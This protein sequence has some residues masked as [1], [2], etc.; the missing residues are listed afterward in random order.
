MYN[1]CSRSL[2]NVCH[3]RQ[4]SRGL[5][6]MQHITGIIIINNMLRLWGCGANLQQTKVIIFSV[7]WLYWLFVSSCCWFRGT[8]HIL[9]QYVQYLKLSLA[10][11]LAFCESDCLNIKTPQSHNTSLPLLVMSCWSGCTVQTCCHAARMLP[12]K[13]WRCVTR[14][15]S[16][17]E[18]SVSHERSSPSADND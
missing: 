16:C 8:R 5:I 18:S 2:T 9:S 12:V 3:T 6:M 17:S 15:V 11:Y 10:S 1:Q 7:K 13:P 14:A 4:S